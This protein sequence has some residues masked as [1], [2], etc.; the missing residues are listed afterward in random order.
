MATSPKLKVLIAHD[1]PLLSAGLSATF[2]DREEFEV[3][4]GNTPILVRVANVVIADF[5]RGVRLA[6]MA[7]QVAPV[8]I[9]SAERGESP[10]REALES[11]VRGYLPSSSAIESIVNGARKVIQGGVVI[12]A[13]IAS[14][15]LN[16]LNSERVTKREQAV[17]SLLMRGLTDKAIATRLGNAVG[18]IKSHVKQLRK[19]L[20]ANSRTEAILIAQRRGLLPREIPHREPSPVNLM[21]FKLTLPVVGSSP[22]ASSHRIARLNQR[23]EQ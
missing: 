7:D 12:D 23:V 14:M 1:D 4:V 22:S 5:D 10:I 17:L 2:R 3:I 21:K 15:V 9:V 11:G 13:F 18:T 16:N 20:G 19:K 6:A 8:M